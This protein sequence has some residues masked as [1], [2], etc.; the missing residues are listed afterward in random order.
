M[1]NILIAATCLLAVL[2]GSAQD[3]E[4]SPSIGFG[5]GI[6][7]YQGDLQPNSFTLRQSNPFFSV[8]L[9]QPLTRH[10]SLR[11]GLL[12][13]KVEASDRYNRDY[14]QKRN[15]S[16]Q[17]SVHEVYLGF[18]AYAFPASSSNITPYL[19]AGVAA[20]HFNP[21]TYTA[22]GEKVFLQPLSTEGQGLNSYPERKPYLLNQ[23]ALAGGLGI[24][25]NV[26]DAFSFSIEFNQRKTF[27]DYLDDV[28][29]N[30]VD[31]QTLM[32]AKGALAVEMAF[33][34]NE[35]AGGASYPSHGEQRGTPLEKDWYYFGGFSAEI[36]LGAVKHSVRS[37]FKGQHDWYYKRCPRVY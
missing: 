33:R 24:R 23:A 19:F 17:S 20:F 7:N 4:R 10:V 22:G 35:L 16:F 27:T 2:I 3:F 29:S 9:K 6:M 1:K 12:R 32:A 8:Y 30:Y 11:A 34:G 31:R 13:G 25:Y 15:L 28:S 36:K 21:Y 37:L 14:L 26:S 5:T 18:E